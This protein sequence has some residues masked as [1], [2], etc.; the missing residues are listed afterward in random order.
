M[1][2]SSAGTRTA[3]CTSVTDCR[4]RHDARSGRRQLKASPAGCWTSGPCYALSV[5]ASAF[6]CPPGCPSCQ[7]KTL[8]G[9]WCT[10]APPFCRSTPSIRCCIVAS[11]QS[12][13]RGPVRRTAMAPRRRHASCHA[14][15]TCWA[16][17]QCAYRVGACA[18]LRLHQAHCCRPPPPLLAAGAC[19]QERGPGRAAGVRPGCSSSWQHR[20]RRQDQA[21]QPGLCLPP[22]CGA[23]DCC[24]RRRRRTREHLAA[25][26]LPRAPAGLHLGRP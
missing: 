14:E 15:A 7:S 22:G 10:P 18:A 19:V 4:R 1:R 16:S 17:R 8:V 13:H 20:A 12:R 6:C 23:S 2:N 21:R 26:A 25:N 24:S 5:H 3:A 9:C 11:A